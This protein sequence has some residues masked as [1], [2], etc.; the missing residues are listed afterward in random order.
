MA[1]DL[2]IYTLACQLATGGGRVHAR[3]PHG[4]LRGRH[5]EWSAVCMLQ[6]DTGGWIDKCKSNAEVNRWLS[7]R[8]IMSYIVPEQLPR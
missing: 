4:Q 6:Q 7:G 2:H 8:Q 5:Y 3:Q 1:A